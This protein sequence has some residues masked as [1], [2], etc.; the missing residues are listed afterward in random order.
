MKKPKVLI[1][2]DEA[3]I[4]SIL[5]ALLTKNGYQVEAVDSG[6]SGLDVYAQF[7][8][9]VLLLDLKMGGIDGIKVMEILDKQLKADCKVIIMTAH[10]EVRSAVEAMKK[11][12][13]D[14]LQK[15][16]DND[17]LLA[18]ISR[19]VEMVTLKRRVK[20]LE[21]QL[22]ETYRFE[23]IVGVSDKMESTFALMR[24]FAATDGTVLVCGE[25]GTGKE[26]IVRA[27]HQAS[28]R[29]SGPFVIV[30]CGAIPSNLI[31]SEFFGHEAGSFTDAK[32]LRKGKFE[33][34]DGG[35]LFLDEIGELTSEAQVKLLRIIEE[36]TFS[37]VG[38]NKS[39][40]VDV[41]VMAATN[42]DLSTMVQEKKFR[43]DLYWRLNVLSLSVCPLRERKEDM[44]LLVEH[45]L[46]RYAT[47]LGI[48]QPVVSDK[49][50]DLLMAYDWPGNVRE[51]QNCIYSAITVTS[52]SAIE[53]D[54]LPKRISLDLKQ[55]DLSGV[56][57]DTSL[58]EIAAQA[59][60]KAEQEVINR[61]LSETGGN[62]EKAAD[63][64]GIGR[65]TLYRKLRQYGI[66]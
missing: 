64:L 5:S 38:G 42:Q 30:N 25:S 17:E 26:L 59:T 12:A 22:E 43:E 49:A 48:E 66:E 14:Y 58:A 34:A 65:K 50:L 62:R 4:R 15:P 6:E 40:A 8:P 35:T 45:F 29:K 56:V 21:D 37:R 19:A 23:N 47:P 57:M 16:F 13:F 1:V 28:K 24:K 11:G 36:G 31:E 54:D 9:A 10:G 61:V 20:Q 27:I 44:P 51:L 46:E 18:L 55:P 3:N 60:A 7:M 41:R 53:S 52:N 32:K 33:D 39:I 2:D 63:M